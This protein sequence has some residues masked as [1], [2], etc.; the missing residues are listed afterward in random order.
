MRWKE[1]KIVSLETEQSNVFTAD[2]VASVEARQRSIAEV[3]TIVTR[4]AGV[5]LNKKR[6]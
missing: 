6:W 3:S 4:I 1:L 2:E 5:Y